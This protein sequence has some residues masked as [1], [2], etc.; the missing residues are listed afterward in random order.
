LRQQQTSYK[1]QYTPFDKFINALQTEETKKTYKKH[2]KAFLTFTG[3]EDYS[4]LITKLTDDEKHEAIADFITHNRN[5]QKIATATIKLRFSVIKRFYS[6]NR[7]KLDWEHLA[8]FK[9]KSKGKKIDD[10]LYTKDEIDQM[11]L[12]AD[13]RE[14]VVVYTLLSTGIR[15]GG[16]ADIKFKDMTWI[17]EYKLYRFRVYADSDDSNDRYIT[18][19]TPECAN[20][21]NKYFESR[22]KQGDTIKPTSP[23]IYR[24]LARFD[25]RSKVVI[26]ENNFDMPMDSH[27]LQQILTRLQRK[28][29]V[30]QREKENPD[31]PGRI[32]KEMMRCHAFRKMFNTICIENNMNHSVKERLLG[33][34]KEQELDFNYYRPDDSKLLTEYLKA[35]NDLTVSNEHRLIT[36]NEKLKDSFEE[37]GRKLEEVEK[38]LGITTTNTTFQKD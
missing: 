4:D 26:Y 14:K 37:Y 21:I 24:K 34:K 10:R 17:P 12:H 20:I 16:L 32:R 3:F 18:F 31:M 8:S 5:N 7:I 13:L 30:V 23:L 28:S 35:V 33:H 22:E 19:C 36:E 38:R 29:S 11:L 27:G 15:V 1:S 9:G 25:Q 2:L 6:I